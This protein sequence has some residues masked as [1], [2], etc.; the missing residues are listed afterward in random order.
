MF[1][2]GGSPSRGNLTVAP[3]GSKPLFPAMAAPRV[4]TDG[5]I[6]PCIPSRAPSPPF[7]ADW[8]HA[9]WLLCDAGPNL[10]AVGR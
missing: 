6:A 1:Q 8:V 2:H 5:F 4:R 9:M 3:G 7:G 10:R